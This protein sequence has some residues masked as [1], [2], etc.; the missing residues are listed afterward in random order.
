MLDIQKASGG[1]SPY[2]IYTMDDHKTMEDTLSTF[3]NIN[4]EMFGFNT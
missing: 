4:K 3:L 1:L 2:N